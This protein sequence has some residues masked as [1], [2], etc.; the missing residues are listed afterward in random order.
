MIAAAAAIFIL[1]QSTPAIHTLSNGATVC[2][3]PE[4]NSK[5]YAAQILV[6]SGSAYQSAETDG[7][8][9]LIEHLLFLAGNGEIQVAAE[10]NGSWMNGTTFREVSRFYVAGPASSWEAGLSQLVKLIA[11]ARISE[12]NLSKEKRVVLEEIAIQ[13][14]DPDS[15]MDRELWSKAFGKSPWAMRTSG[16]LAGIERISFEQASEALKDHYAGENI[17]LVVTGSFDPEGA[18]RIASHLNELPRGKRMSPPSFPAIAFGRTAATSPYDTERVGFGFFAPGIGS[19]NYSAVRIAI[20]TIAGRYGFFSDSELVSRV[21]FGPS[22]SGSLLTVSVSGKKAATEIEKE[23]IEL[24]RAAPT[25][26]THERYRNAKSAVLANVKATQR[27]PSSIG[28]QV[29]LG[30]QFGDPQ[31]GTKELERVE[32]VTHEQVVDALRLFSPENAVVLI[33]SKR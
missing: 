23:A 8:H 18:L 29:G 24:L 2:L 16:S 4:T 5:G 26:L 28:F 19:S 21:H 20:E 9:H 11:S 32:A 7:V 31:F 22:E 27:Q 6:R 1:V 10:A 33:W 3:Y 14:L 15:A 13:D 12:D 25:A 17:V 30:V